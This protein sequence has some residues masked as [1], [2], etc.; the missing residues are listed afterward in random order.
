MKIGM[1]LQKNILSSIS[2]KIKILI[3]LLI[4]FLNRKWKQI[5][6]DFIHNG[7]DKEKY[8]DKADFKRV[9]NAYTQIIVQILKGIAELDDNQ[10]FFYSLLNNFNFY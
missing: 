1:L 8:A 2:K 10:V 7:L 3:Y 6:A 9:I 5:L 4:F